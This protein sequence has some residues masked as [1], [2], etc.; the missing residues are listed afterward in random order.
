MGPVRVLEKA[1]TR[2]EVDS[3]LQCADCFVSLHRSEG[4][5]LAMAES[6]AIGKPVVATAYSGNMDFMDERSA[7][8]V[9]YEL[10]E[11]PAGC[12]PYRTGAPWAEPSTDHAAKQM[13]T[14]FADSVLRGRIAAS[15]RRRVREQ[16]DPAVVGER[17]LARLRA[18]ERRRKA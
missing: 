17:I 10:G 5:G 2:A 11:V 8:L 6:M 3:L 13:L 7:F 1:L 16:L 15:G 9:E 4:F 12:F 18:M 14:V